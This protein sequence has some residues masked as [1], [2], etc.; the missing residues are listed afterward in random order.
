MADNIRPNLDNK[1]I[2][3]GED[4]F[5]V[6]GRVSVEN[7]RY[8]PEDLKIMWGLAD[9]ILKNHNDM[10]YYVCMKLIDTEIQNSKTDK[11]TKTEN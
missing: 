10:V 7:C 4:R 5:Y 2:N 6:L 9:T 8:T 1:L 3:I 11:K